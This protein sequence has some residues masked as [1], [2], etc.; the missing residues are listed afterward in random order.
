[1]CQYDVMWWDG[2]H[3][4]SDNKEFKVV[5]RRCV[6]MEQRQ[7]GGVGVEGVRGV[8]GCQIFRAEEDP[9]VGVLREGGGEE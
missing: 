1:M 6:S 2:I 4:N 7:E 8:W 3:N 9:E 5:V